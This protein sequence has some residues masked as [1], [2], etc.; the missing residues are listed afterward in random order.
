MVGL[1]MGLTIQFVRAWTEP[2]QSPP[3]GNVGAPINTSDAVQLK[4]GGLGID[5]LLD[6]LHG[7]RIRENAGAGKVLT[8]DA[9]GNASWQPAGG[10]GY[11]FTYYCSTSGT[12]GGPRCRNA[13]GSQRFCPAGYTQ[14]AYLGWW[15]VCYGEGFYLF[16]ARF[17]QPGGTCGPSI[18]FFPTGYVGKAYVCSK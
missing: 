16:G 15:G 6:L 17:L 4:T 7:P 14:K 3:G 2:S 12:Y 8:S 10:G 11:S 13:G 1:I 18:S 9:D 5:G